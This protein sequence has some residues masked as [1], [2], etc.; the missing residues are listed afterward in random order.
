MAGVGDEVKTSSLCGGSP[1]S[2]G[3]SG[4]WVA[5]RPGSVYAGNLILNRYTARSVSLFFAF[6]K[7]FW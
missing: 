5:L 2:V 6:G 7:P 3:S 1:K 4:T